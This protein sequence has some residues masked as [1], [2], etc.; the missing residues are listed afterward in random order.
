MSSSK[1]INNT[2]DNT[3]NFLS[4]LFGNNNGVGEGSEE[5]ATT[6]STDSNSTNLAHLIATFDALKKTGPTTTS[7]NKTDKMSFNCTECGCIKPNTEELEIHIKVEHLNF[8]PF[9]C[10][11][12]QSTRATDTQMREHVNSSHKNSDNNKFIYVDN[13]LARRILKVMMDNSVALTTTSIPKKRKHEVINDNIPP[14]PIVSVLQTNNPFPDVDSSGFSFAD[15]IGSI[16]KKPKIE[17]ESADKPS[18]FNF[19]SNPSFLSEIDSILNNSHLK[20]TP[21]P[22]ITLNFAN[23]SPSHHGIASTNVLS[24]EDTKHQKMLAKKRV[25]GLCGTC[26]KPVTAGSR[27]VHIF[28]HLAR[29]YDKHRFRCKFPK[30]DVAHYRKDQLESHHIKVHGGINSDLLEDC[31]PAL[32]S[33]CHELSMEL[34]GTANN[35]PGPTAPEAQILFDKM[36]KEQLEIMLKKRKKRRNGDMKAISMPKMLLNQMS[37]KSGAPY[38]KDTV[39]CKMCN[40]KII[41]KVRSF[42][43]LWHL[44][45]HYGSGRFRCKHCPFSHDRAIQVKTHAK[46]MHDDEKGVD[47]MILQNMDVVYEFSKECFGSLV[48]NINRDKKCKT[49]RRS[50]R[51]DIDPNISEINVEDLEALEDHFAD[52]P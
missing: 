12:C 4:S 13:E 43:V 6:S 46:S 37:G 3:S 7:I 14:T 20:N 9:E 40:K 41:L 33:L 49:T 29:D 27:Q 28:Y 5:V 2:E 8:L 25:I 45:K 48:I 36:Q 16:Q 30:C 22:D 11:H 31:S 19:L 50:S 42:H 15:L 1:I 44:S 21:S 38:D 34:L 32:A 47:D 35:N 39:E 52:S 51:T 10:P 24:L 23:T 18:Q 26:Q 17:V